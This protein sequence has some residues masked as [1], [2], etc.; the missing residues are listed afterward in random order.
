MPPNTLLLRSY[1]GLTVDQT[2]DSNPLILTAYEN[3]GSRNTTDAEGPT[4]HSAA[5]VIADRYNNIVCCLPLLL[6][7]ML[8][9]YRATKKHSSDFGNISPLR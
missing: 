3:C 5:A 6:L 2:S 7:L 9:V 4:V 1:G 8:R